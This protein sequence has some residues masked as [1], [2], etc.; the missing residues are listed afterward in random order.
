MGRGT[1]GG[2][3]EAPGVRTRCHH[4][5]ELLEGVKE[6]R[7]GTGIHGGKGERKGEERGRVDDRNVKRTKRRVEKGVEEKRKKTLAG[8]I[9]RATTGGRIAGTR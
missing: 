2:R 5:Y 1:K 4:K 9:H 7:K 6:Q 3:E 8:I